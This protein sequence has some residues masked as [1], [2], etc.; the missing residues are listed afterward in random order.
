MTNKQLHNNMGLPYL[1]TRITQQFKNVNE[2]F[3]K[4]EGALHYKID[5]RSVKPRLKPRQPQYMCIL[6][7]AQEDHSDL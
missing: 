5:K 6:L 3:H 4:T 1:S 2:K 7:E